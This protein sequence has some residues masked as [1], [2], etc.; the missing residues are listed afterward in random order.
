MAN[1]KIMVF[2]CQKG[3]AEQRKNRD[4]YFI[5]HRGLKSTIACGDDFRIHRSIWGT[6]CNRKFPKEELNMG[7]K[8]IA[9]CRRQIE[10]VFGGREWKEGRK[11][12][13]SWSLVLHQGLK[14]G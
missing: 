12:S 1:N 8:P 7:Q 4:D 6:N 3:I 2:L 14:G 9:I 13:W 5:C 11:G 10:E